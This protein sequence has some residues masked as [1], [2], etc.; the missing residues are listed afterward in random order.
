[1]SARDRRQLQATR[2]G[3]LYWFA[4]LAALALLGCASEPLAPPDRSF[5]GRFSAIATQGDKRDSVSGRFVVELRGARQT[6]DLATP[7][8]TTVARIDVGPD[9]ARASG[10]GMPESRGNDPDQLAEQL[11]GW[12]LPVTGLADWIEGRPVPSR[13]ARVERNGGQPTA[14]EQDGWTIRYAE[15]FAGG[16]PRLIV[17]ERPAAPLAPGVVLRLVLDDPAA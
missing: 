5:T 16:R 2:V 10:P 1:M 9:G 12:R 14:I 4:M 11:L 13:P 8:G 17:M 6:I 7:V 15:R 3:A